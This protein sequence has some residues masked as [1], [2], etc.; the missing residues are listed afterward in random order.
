[1][2]GL[3][4]VPVVV[5]GKRD[6]LPAERGDVGKQLVRDADTLGAELLDSLV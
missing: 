3:G 5:A 6:V 4:S 2:G 1:M